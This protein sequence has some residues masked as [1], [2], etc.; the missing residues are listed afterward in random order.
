MNIISD[1]KD[2]L[3]RL[4]RRLK[5]EGTR[6]RSN[7]HSKKTQL[8]ISLSVLPPNRLALT[9]REETDVATYTNDILA[10]ANNIVY[11]PVYS[12]ECNCFCHLEGKRASAGELIF[13]SSDCVQECGESNDG[14][15]KYLN[16]KIHTVQN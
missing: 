8:P 15:R 5:Y 9:L 3:T 14:Y 7:A 4:K 10:E 13:H 6:I 1:F 2:E 11:S 12:F 16:S